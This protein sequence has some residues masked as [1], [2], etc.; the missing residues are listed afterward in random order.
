MCT[1]LFNFLLA[2]LLLAAAYV[3]AVQVE[4]VG[5]AYMVSSGIPIRNLGH[6]S[7]LADMALTLRHGVTKFKVKMK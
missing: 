1:E 3:S 7:E 4:T 6:A 5:D 2:Y